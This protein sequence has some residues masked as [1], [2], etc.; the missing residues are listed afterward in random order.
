[1]L[2]ATGHDR[3]CEAGT[4]AG[5]MR[6]AAELR[7][8]VALVDVGLPDG[9]GSQLACDL[10]ALPDPPRIVL[11]SADADAADDAAAQ[12][13]GAVGFVAKEELDGARLSTLLD[14]P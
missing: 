14:G 13:A 6:A 5:A 2:R 12:R 7:P 8:E 9:D 1:M 11:I 4:V 3:V 10:P